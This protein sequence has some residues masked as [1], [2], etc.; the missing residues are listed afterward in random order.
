MKERDGYMGVRDFPGDL[1]RAYTDVGFIYH[2]PRVTIWKDPLIEATRTKALGLMHKQVVKDSSMSRTG[3]PDYVITM[4]KPGENAEPITHKPSGFDSYIGEM[5]APNERKE[6]DPHTNK[7]SHIV[8]QRYASPV[9]FDIRQGNT[10]QHE[11]AREND[12][13]RHICPLQLDVIERCMTLW[14]NPGNLVFSPFAGIGSEGWC[15]LKMG[16]RFV[17]AELKRSYWEVACRNLKHAEN[18]SQGDLFAAE[19]AQ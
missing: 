11:S 1:I 8:W 17:G 19:A 16:R 18:V 10:L 4:R 13:E 7:Y 15:A 9:W 14:S 12:D 3:G 2:S 5:P 6:S